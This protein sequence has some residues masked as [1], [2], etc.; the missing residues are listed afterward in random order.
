M[1]TDLNLKSKLTNSNLTSWLSSNLDL[2][3]PDPDLKMQRESKK[4][5]L[6]QL[7]Q[8]CFLLKMLKRFSNLRLCTLLSLSSTV[9]V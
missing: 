7:I 4:K 5:T 2:A 8:N 6:H 1:L 3:R 9:Y